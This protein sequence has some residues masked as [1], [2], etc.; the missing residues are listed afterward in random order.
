[1]KH[2]AVFQAVEIPS[3]QDG[4]DSSTVCMPGPGE[5]CLGAATLHASSLLHSSE[6]LR[7]L[8]NRLSLCIDRAAPPS[9]HVELE[10]FP[11]PEMRLYLLREALSRLGSRISI[12]LQ[13]RNLFY[14]RPDDL[15][16]S[17]GQALYYVRIDGSCAR[18]SC[19]KAGED[20]PEGWS[21]EMEPSMPIDPKWRE[22]VVG[23]WEYCSASRADL[24][25]SYFFQIMSLRA[26]YWNVLLDRL[27]IEVDQWRLERQTAGAAGSPSSLVSRL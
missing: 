6:D 17:G 18:S 15:M 3:V 11:S 12:E 2:E 1:M 24:F 5:G 9:P 23:E 25:D 14:M 10:D 27:Y 13:Y 26:G 16:M 7:D 8:L 4:D 19:T 21:L 20:W 22:L